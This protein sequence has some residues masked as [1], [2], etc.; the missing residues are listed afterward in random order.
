MQEAPH[1][2]VLSSSHNGATDENGDFVPDGTGRL[3]LDCPRLDWPD[4]VRLW[5][6]LQAAIDEWRAG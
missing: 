2:L 4:H 1:Q 5:K 3:S 6:L